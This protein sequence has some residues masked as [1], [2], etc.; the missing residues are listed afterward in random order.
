MAHHISSREITYSALGLEDAFKLLVLGPTDADEVVFFQAGAFA[1]ARLS[2]CE[3]DV[4]ARRR[5]GEMNRKE[6]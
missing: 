1:C 2:V 4:A 5:G 3:K 6:E